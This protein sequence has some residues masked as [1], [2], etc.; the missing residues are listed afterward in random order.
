VDGRTGEVRVTRGGSAYRTVRVPGA[1]GS[2]VLSPDGRLLAV[3]VTRGVAVV[4]VDAG[5]LRVRLVGAP[6]AVTDVAWSGDGARVWAVTGRTVVG[7][8]YATGRLL[9]DEP[10]A[11]YQAVLASA[12]PSRVWVV[13]RSGGLRELSVADGTVR[14]R[15]T[16]DDTVYGA[17]GDAA[18]RYAYL[19]GE[20]ADWLVSLTRRTV[21][22]VRVLP[23]C[24]GAGAVFDPGGRH[25]YLP[26]GA[27]LGVLSTAS[28]RPGTA[29]AVPV[30]GMA[31]IAFDPTGR[32]VVA[33]ENGE[34]LRSRT[35]DLRRIRL[36]TLDV[37]NCRPLAHQIAVSTRGDLLPVGDGTG[38][39]VCER[40]GWTGTGHDGSWH[41]IGDLPPRAMT[42]LAACFS[43]SGN[44]FAV[45]YYDGTVA[46][47]PTMRAVPAVTV[48]D[49]VGA[50]RDMRIVRGRLLV[51]T[52]NG[53]LQSLPLPPD[54]LTNRTLAA[55]ARTT[56]LRAD[57]LGLTT[58]R[59]R[60]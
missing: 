54:H 23:G 22:A 33:T 45:G 10:D 41:A 40:I 56:L 1:T 34:F 9:L 6:G 12:D 2:P 5:L 32:L 28:A 51:A 44:L 13:A 43:P 25:V 38:M 4:D 47:R 53:V 35:A 24:T 11:W 37:P 30:A 39:G 50:V 55:S 29:V 49:V 60:S 8:R 7:W 57:A 36:G 18:G 15:I 26:C 52:R 16:V 19:D 3:A 46:V 59:P 48:P 14:H 17:A 20:R 31:A 21:R 58:V 42:A 27:T